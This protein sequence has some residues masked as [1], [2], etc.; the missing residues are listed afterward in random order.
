ML[1][2][3][4]LFL[5]LLI[6][7]CSGSSSTEPQPANVVGTWIASFSSGQGVSCQVGQIASNDAPIGSHGS[8]VVTC[9]ALPQTQNPA[10]SISWALNG[11]K[12]SIHLNGLPDY[13]LLGT[14]DGA[15]YAGSFT[16][17]NVSGTFTAS[18]Q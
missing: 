5:S 7:S 8:Y 17:G 12:F 10:G 16:L 18:K 1:R 2:K 14:V 11:D 4:S 15:V 9:P 3:A 13:Y 6:T